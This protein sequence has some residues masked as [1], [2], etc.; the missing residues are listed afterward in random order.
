MTARPRSIRFARIDAALLTG[1]GEAT[2]VARVIV[3]EE[4]VVGEIMRRGTRWE[5]ILAGG[6]PSGLSSPDSRQDLEHQIRLYH[7]GE[8]SNAT[9]VAGMR[10]KLA[11]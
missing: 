1:C 11:G 8:I 2:P 6:T 10:L 4:A 9:P 5:Y 3:D 7:F